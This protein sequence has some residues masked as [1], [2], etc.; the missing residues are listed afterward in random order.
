M[1]GN[2]RAGLA[3]A[4]RRLTS[5]VLETVTERHIVGVRQLLFAP[6]AAPVR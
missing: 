5:P 2:L 4:S 1:A 6:P 3:A